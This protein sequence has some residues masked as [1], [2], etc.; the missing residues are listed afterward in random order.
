M[1]HEHH[2]NSLP[3]ELNA[4][5]LLNAWRRRAVVVGAIFAVLSIV[6]AFLAAAVNHDGIDHLLRSYLLGFIL[7]WSF[8]VG[9]L[10]LLMVQYLSGGK[11]GLL[12]RRPLEAMSRCLPL[13]IVLFL[14]IGIF[15]KKLYL[16]AKYSDATTA[17][18]QHLITHEQAHA[19][20]Y[21]HPMLSVP[22]VWIQS[23]VCFAIWL[24]FMFFLNKWGLQ[25]DADTHPNVRFWQVRLENL[26][27]FGV[28]VYSITMS[29]CAIDWVMSLDPTWYSS[30]YGFLF[31]VGQGYAVLALSIITVL[32]LSQA[33]PMKTV[34]RK[35][36]QHDLGKLAFAF[37][38]LNIYIAFSQFLIIWSGNLPEE[39]PWYLDRIRGGWGVIASLDF[40]FHWLVPFTLL[41]SRDLK[42][43]KERLI[44]V[45][46]IMIF[47]RC[48]DLFWLIE[49]NFAD[50]RRNLH[51]SFGIL[52]YMTVPVVVICIWMWFYFGELAKRPLI[53][54]N[55]PH[56]V[57][58]LEAEHAHA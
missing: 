40:V 22:S 25:R 12:L 33:E 24:V 6:L 16:W 36:E 20:T 4:P 13:T 50:A 19:I 23:A 47:A 10:A 48:W 27:G 7:C 28:L 9:G 44:L 57:E 35:T 52:E 45:C 21:K 1:A 49:P 42:R 34:L 3:S 26:S 11:W 56:L 5:L 32:R 29:V 54:T 30:I 46:K 55:D 41:L 31:L 51:F 18:R 8:T 37:V 15:M 17:Y 53:Q 39:I 43:N 58:I 14:P 38:M 2:A